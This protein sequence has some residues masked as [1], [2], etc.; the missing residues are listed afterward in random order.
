MCK[1]ILWCRAKEWGQLGKVWG[2]LG[3]SISECSERAF[4]ETHTHTHW[5]TK[6]VREKQ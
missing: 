4:G 2:H 6:C 1:T 3:K 5:L